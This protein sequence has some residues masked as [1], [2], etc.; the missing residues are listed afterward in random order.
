MQSRVATDLSFLSR[1]NNQRQKK[2]NN[3]IY[4]ESF[5]WWFGLVCSADVGFSNNTENVQKLKE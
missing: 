2:S 4:V 5:S 1:F 3:L